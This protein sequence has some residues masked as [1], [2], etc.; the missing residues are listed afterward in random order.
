M[1][2]FIKDES[3]KGCNQKERGLKNIEESRK[4]APNSAEALM[5]L[6][7]LQLCKGSAKNAV[8]S[9]QKAL[10]INSN[11]HH[12]ADALIEKASRPQR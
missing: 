5:L 2:A 12:E 9:F 10:S 8:E 11:L 4:A 7:K 6:G 1:E 3:K